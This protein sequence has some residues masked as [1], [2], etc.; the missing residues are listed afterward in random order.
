MILLAEMTPFD[1]AVAISLLYLEIGAAIW[2][3]LFSSGIAAE[4]KLERLARG[5]AQSVPAVVF[6]SVAAIL[7]WP[8]MIGKWGRG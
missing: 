2:A 7:L 4:V 8:W 5:K 6:A 3:Y 1:W